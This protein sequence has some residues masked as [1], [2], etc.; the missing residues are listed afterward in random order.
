MKLSHALA[1]AC[2]LVFA[3]SAQAHPMLEHAEPGA[4]SV[5]SSAPA[6]L[7]IRFTQAL[8]TAS[9]TIDVTDVSG[10]HVAAGPAR[11]PADDPRQ[12]VVPLVP[13]DPGEY[14]VV[15]RAVSVDSHATRGR[16]TFRVGR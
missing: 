12:L 13:L 8:E 14:L 11:R 9:S 15:W 16:F 10:R 6:E 3:N 1:V 7:R 5:V 4:G 2:A